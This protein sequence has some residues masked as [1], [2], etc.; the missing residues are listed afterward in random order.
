MPRSGMTEKATG[1]NPWN[2]ALQKNRAS[3][4]EPLYQGMASAM[5]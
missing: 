3:A 4:P 5:P 1:F 2:M